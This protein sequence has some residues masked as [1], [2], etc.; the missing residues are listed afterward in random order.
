MLDIQDLGNQSAYGL[1][2]DTTMYKNVKYFLMTLTFKNIDSR[3]LHN[4]IAIVSNE[5]VKNAAQS[6]ITLKFIEKL[7]KKFNEEVVER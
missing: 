2:K 3:W 5:D 1:L 6:A 4:Q 7:P